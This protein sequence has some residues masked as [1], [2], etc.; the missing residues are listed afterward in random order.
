LT[1]DIA[2]ERG[3]SVDMAGFDAA[4][5]Q[6]RERAREASKFASVGSLPS[7]LAAR[8]QPTQFL[9]YDS[10]EQDGCVVVALLKD[11]A[12]VQRIEAGDE[13]VVL[14]DRTPFYA[15]SGGQVGDTGELVGGD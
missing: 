15:E 12:S 2:R 3:L 14:L 1:A 6:Q 13:A 7:E 5:A 4:M 8:L 11:G 10:H 9:G